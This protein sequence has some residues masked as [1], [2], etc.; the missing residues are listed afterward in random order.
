[1]EEMIISLILSGFF[2]W[3][4]AL[5]FLFLRMQ[6]HYRKLTKITQK[7]RLDDLL[8]ELITR[9]TVLTKSQSEL[10]QALDTV[11]A[12]LCGTISRIGYVKFNPFG[13]TE[14]EKSFVLAF[15]DKKGTGAVITFMYTHEGLRVYAKQIAEGK[16][17]E[18]SLTDEEKHA[19]KT[20]I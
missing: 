6:S 5:S 11:H 2:G 13:K 10:R 4:L 9:N 16:A 14:G 8:E 17:T 12:E 3:M 15:L 7:E 1:M 18:Y 20:A 19:L